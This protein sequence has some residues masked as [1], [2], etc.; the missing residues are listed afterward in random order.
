MRHRHWIFALALAAPVAA[1]QPPRA[2]SE[3][4]VFGGATLTT[5]SRDGAPR[6][7]LLLPAIYTLRTRL[8]AGALLGLRFTRYL[9]ARAALE[10]DLTV[11]PSQDVEFRAEVICIPG[12][13]CPR[14][15]V[16]GIVGPCPLAVPDFLLEE[17]VTSWQYGAGF[18]YDLAGDHVRPYLGASFGASTTVGLDETHTDVRF[19]LLAGV[20][21]G[22][23]RLRGRLELGDFI[24]SSHFLT[25]RS[26]HDLQA[27]AGFSVGLP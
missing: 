8:D 13:P 22:G 1:A 23:G 14:G 5:L 26:Q 11:V 6:F 7:P 27:R 9:G 17:R 15:P 3:L 20:K 16:C 25:D 24:T 18:T 2:H 10:V 4:T 19:G 12:Q 21:L